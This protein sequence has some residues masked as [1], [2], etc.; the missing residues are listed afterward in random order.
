MMHQQQQQTSTQQPASAAATAALLAA[1]A[2]ATSQ[3]NGSTP[4]SVTLPSSNGT[5]ASNSNTNTVNQYAQFTT[6]PTGST[7]GHGSNVLN[8]VGSAAQSAAQFL[9]AALANG[10]LVRP[11]LFFFIIFKLLKL[12][13]SLSLA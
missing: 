7:V 2:A 6:S 9:P 5:G 12:T 3:S 1:A 11:S 13:L 8:G 4:G 10:G